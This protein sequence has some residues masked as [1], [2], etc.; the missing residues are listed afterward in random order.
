MAVKPK[1]FANVKRN[2]AL[3]QHSFSYR[4]L[5]PTPSKSTTSKEG[6][7]NELLPSFVVYA[8]CMF[9]ELQINNKAIITKYMFIPLKER[10]NKLL[11]ILLNVDTQELVKSTC[12]QALFE[13]QQLDSNQA[14][15]TKFVSLILTRLESY[16]PMYHNAQQWSNIQT[17]K[18]HLRRVYTSLIQTPI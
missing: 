5:I 18:V 7:N 10:Q 16:N 13:L 4:S 1:R 3:F 8:E 12:D 11:E 9:T 2:T 17:A 15:T 6:R 14:N